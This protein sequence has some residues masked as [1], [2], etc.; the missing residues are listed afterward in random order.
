MAYALVNFS[1]LATRLLSPHRVHVHAH[2]RVRVHV[3]VHRVLHRASRQLLTPS[4]LL[5]Q[6]ARRV[7]IR[8]RTSSKAMGTGLRFLV[9]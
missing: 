4:Q 8:P 3:R 9:D 1:L 5:Y 2:V 6:R 7:D